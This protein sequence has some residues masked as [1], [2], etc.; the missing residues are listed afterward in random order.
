[1]SV[2]TTPTESSTDADVDLDSSYLK[3]RGPAKRSTR[4]WKTMED[5]NITALII[6]GEHSVSAIQDSICRMIG[7][8]VLTSMNAP[9]TMDVSTS[10]KTSKV[11]TAVNVGKDTN[12]DVTEELVRSS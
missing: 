11:H 12:S 2:K 9:K 4:V 7:G 6:M 1:M 3:T 5:V 8:R 10:V